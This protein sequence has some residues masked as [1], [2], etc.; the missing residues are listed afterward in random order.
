[1]AL[2]GH[3]EAELSQSCRHRQHLVKLIFV[4]V[5]GLSQL[6]ILE[7]C[8]S[9]DDSFYCIPSSLFE[10]SPCIV[11]LI[12]SLTCILLIGIRLSLLLGPHPCRTRAG[13]TVALQKGST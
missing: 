8:S 13:T 1:M 10:L 6:S 5:L 7:T 3:L 2:E 4:L 9:S 11:D 12:C